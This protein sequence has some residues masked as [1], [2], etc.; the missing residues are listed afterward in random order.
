MTHL[1]YDQN[2][3]ALNEDQ[4]KIIQ[5]GFY[6]CNENDQIQIERSVDINLVKLFL[7]VI[8]SEENKNEISNISKHNIYMLFLLSKSWGI[9]EYQ[10]LFGN[11]LFGSEYKTNINPNYNELTQNSISSANDT[12]KIHSLKYQAEIEFSSVFNDKC[13]VDILDDE[14]PW[15]YQSNPN[16][17]NPFIIIYFKDGPHEINRYTIKMSRIP[18]TSGNSKKWDIEG[19]AVGR[20]KNSLPVWKKMDSVFLVNTPKA[21]ESVTRNSIIQNTYTAIK[22]TSKDKKLSLHSIAFECNPAIQLI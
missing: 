12:F 2:D 10:N 19:L 5:S 15:F 16:D 11:Y 22:L 13:L 4:S 20:K 7:K 9:A 6:K 18:I 21:N 17:Q 14:N 1:L 8:S 3:F